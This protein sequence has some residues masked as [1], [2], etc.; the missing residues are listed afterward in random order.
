MADTPRQGH[1]AMRRRAGPDDTMPT[2]STA[3][4]PSGCHTHTPCGPAP[5]GDTRSCSPC[6]AM[7]CPATP[8]RAS[9]RRAVPCRASPRRARPSPASPC[10]ATP[11]PAS[12]CPAAPRLA[13]PCRGIIFGLAAFHPPNARPQT[14]QTVPSSR[15]GN[16]ARPPASR[17]HPPLDG[18]GPRST[19]SHRNSR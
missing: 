5:G 6:L 11:R 7:P 1:L 13:R 8:C 4:C 18:A 15:V 10:L 9:P 12:P 3:E 17:Y 2:H 14:A 19:V 16:P